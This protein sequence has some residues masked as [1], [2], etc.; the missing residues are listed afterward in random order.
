MPHINITKENVNIY[1]Y[2]KESI[3]VNN[4]QLSIGDLHSNAMLF[5]YFLITHG[6]MKTREDN[7]NKLC[8][9]Y[10]KDVKLLTKNDIK[11]FNDIIDGL[12]IGI[13]P[14]I[15]LIGDEICDRGQNDYFIFK[16][17]NKLKKENVPLEILLSNHS[18][19]FMLPYEQKVELIPPSLFSDVYTLS[20]NNMKTIIEN[21]LISFKEVGSLVENVYKPSLKLI[22]YSLYEN[23]ITLYSHAGIG[24]ETIKELCTIS[25][26]DHKIEY[27]DETIDELANTIDA[28][29]D[30][31]TQCI[32]KGKLPELAQNLSSI[33]SFSIDDPFFRVLWNRNYFGLEREK[34]H[35]GYHMFFVHGHDS[36][37]ET[38]NNI[39]NLDGT[40]GKTANSNIGRFSSL[41]SKSKSTITPADILISLSKE[42]SPETVKTVIPINPPEN[43]PSRGKHSSEFF[44][45]SEKRQY[46][47]ER[48]YEDENQP[49]EAKKNKL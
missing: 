22:S 38:E 4:E 20:L 8:E 49:P 40:L 45:P 18:I 17:I 48:Q 9:I 19:E 46:E 14:L 36:N 47:G 10:L 23:T 37:E 41:A 13:K 7:Y 39:I 16:I 15:R 30:A 11:E 33:E 5:M 21:Q 34:Q 31:F 1:I 28:I 42:K 26:K 25:F 24:L 35:K 44:Y 29:N 3:Q 6:I 2:P 32:T 43:L 12:E 27:K